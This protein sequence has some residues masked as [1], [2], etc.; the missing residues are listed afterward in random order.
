MSFSLPGPVQ[1]ESARL[2]LPLSAQ[3]P[4]A[5]P[6]SSGAAGGAGRGAG[7]AGREGAGGHG[8]HVEGAAPRVILSS[9]QSPRALPGSP[10]SQFQNGF[11]YCLS[12]VYL[13]YLAVRPF[14]PK[15]KQ[16]K[17]NLINLKIQKE[18]PKV[19]NEITIED[20]CL[21]KAANCRCWRSKTFPACDGSH[22]K[23]NK[24]T[25]DNVGPLILKKYNSN[26]LGWNSIL[27]CKIL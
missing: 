24:L 10:G 7:A 3:A 22:D 9:S 27:C 4:E 14:L 16:Q 1:A 2:L 8:P 15:K 17:D 18:N 23:H 11:D 13:H 26:E 20:L 25:G 5:R 6:E 12:S 19:V 21:T